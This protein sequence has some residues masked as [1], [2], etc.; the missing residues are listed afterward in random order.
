MLPHNS[1]LIMW[2]DAQESW[3]HAVPRCADASIA[4]HRGSLVRFSLTFRMA[5]PLPPLG[6][7]YCGQPAALKAKH[8]KYFLFCKPYGKD[9]TCNFWQPCQ[10]AEETAA[11]M[12]AEQQASHPAPQPAP[13]PASQ[14]ANELIPQAVVQ[15]PL[16]QAMQ[17]GAKPAGKPAV[18]QAADAAV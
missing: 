9:T 18:E 17:A 16:P 8:G 1:A 6:T 3:H 7:C 15:E 10:W 4:R 14:T 13:H 2:D 12:R 5:R 11:R